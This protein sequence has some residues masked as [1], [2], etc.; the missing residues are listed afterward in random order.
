MGLRDVEQRFVYMAVRED[1]KRYV[2]KTNNLERRLREHMKE[3]RLNSAGCKGS[4]LTN[5]CPYPT[6]VRDVHGSRYT[7]RRVEVY[8]EI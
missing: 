3:G 2:G 8:Q 5:N 6:G 7:A 4:T 1:G